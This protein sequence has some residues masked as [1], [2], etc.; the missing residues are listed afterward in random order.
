MHMVRFELDKQE[1]DH[2]T[3]VSVLPSDD[4][5]EVRRFATDFEEVV[6]ESD[7]VS[8]ARDGI[9]TRV[10]LDFFEAAAV[11]DDDIKRRRIGTMRHLMRAITLTATVTSAE[12]GI[13][14]YIGESPLEDGVRLPISVELDWLDVDDTILSHL[15]TE[16]MRTAAQAL[17]MHGNDNVPEDLERVFAHVDKSRGLTLQ[18]NQI[19]SCAVDTDAM[20]YFPDE[21]HVRAT[22]HNIYSA[23]QQLVCVTGGLA[24]AYA[25]ELVE[26]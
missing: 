4:I 1:D 7:F 17:R 21:G 11:L 15:G 19:G 18:T 23:E 13:D 12:R 3:V 8:I 9:D 16:Y 5:Q 10:S 14:I 2:L 6:D 26:I 25:D 22:G 20:S 24:I